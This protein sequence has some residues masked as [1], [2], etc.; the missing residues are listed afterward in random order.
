MVKSIMKQPPFQDCYSGL[1]L[2]QQGSKQVIDYLSSSDLLSPFRTSQ[3]TFER[4]LLPLLF[5]KSIL[6]RKIPLPC[7][8][9]FRLFLHILHNQGTLLFYLH[10]ITCAPLIEQMEFFHR[11]TYNLKVDTHIFCHDHPTDISQFQSRNIHILSLHVLS[12]RDLPF[13]LLA[14]IVHRLS[15]YNFNG[16]IP[17]RAF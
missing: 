5:L 1:A 3:A 9:S 11:K 7:V 2:E 14:H 10:I 16:R 17:F 8:R 15:T 13:Q 4:Q 6:L 12:L